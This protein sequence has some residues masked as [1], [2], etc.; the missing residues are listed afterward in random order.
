M[1]WRFFARRCTFFCRMDARME[2]QPAC[3]ALRPSHADG[4]A[5][6]AWHRPERGRATNSCKR[7]RAACGPHQRCRRH[8]GQCAAG[9]AAEPAGLSSCRPPVLARL[10]HV[11]L[12]GHRGEHRQPG[13][14]RAGARFYG[15]QRP[16]PGYVC[17]RAGDVLVARNA[18]LTLRH[19]NGDGAR[20][21][22]AA[23]RT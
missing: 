14:L 17:G 5:D 13:R 3:A 1:L 23:Y 2:E 15:G 16:V 12:L 11:C 22:S 18:P 19:S 8:P 9:V 20:V 6:P 4:P 10:G 21:V 7:P